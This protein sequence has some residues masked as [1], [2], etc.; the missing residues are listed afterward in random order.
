VHFR[1][2]AR[3]LLHLGRPLQVFF[4][5]VFDT[6]LLCVA[7]GGCVLPAAADGNKHIGIKFDRVK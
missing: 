7:V 4:S 5:C 2:Q 1:M 3:T 6:P